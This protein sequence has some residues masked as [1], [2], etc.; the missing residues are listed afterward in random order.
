MDDKTP[1]SQ[2]IVYSLGCLFVL[3]LPVI[4]IL[5]LWGFNF[6][7][8]K[9]AFSFSSDTGSNS[10]SYNFDI[11]PGEDDILGVS[12]VKNDALY[13]NITVGT[14]PAVYL[15]IP[16]ASISGPIVMGNDGESLLREGFWHYPSTVLPGE[17]GVSVI[18]GHRRFHLP[19]ATDTFY[20]L[21]KV[22]IGD[23][24]E[25]NLQDGTWVEFTVVASEVIDPVDL[26]K[27][28]LSQS[29]EAMVK[30][31]TCTPLGTANQRLIVTAKKT[32]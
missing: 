12:T 10:I 11:T 2:L 3:A 20:S 1:A 13:V 30:F 23:R 16:S 8:V 22:Q 18:F 31:V 4:G 21:D 6:D 24:I 7:N 25:I 19:P 5:A 14:N 17:S 15:S 9:N 26:D 28:L 29:S 32:F 27:I